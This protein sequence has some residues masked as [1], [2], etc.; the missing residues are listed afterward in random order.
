MASF[1]PALW[2]KYQLNQDYTS[3]MV[4]VSELN[5]FYM[6]S[7]LLYFQMMINRSTDLYYLIGESISRSCWAPFVV[8]A[9]IEPSTFRPVVERF[10]H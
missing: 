2:H 3:N 9:R 5:R 7:Q 8:E 6:N 10:I 4:A 1:Q